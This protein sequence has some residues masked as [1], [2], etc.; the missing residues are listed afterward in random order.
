MKIGV[1]GAAHAGVAAAQAAAKE[2]A[3]VVLFSA[4]K[5]LPYFRPRLPGVAFGAVDEASI[6]MHPFEWHKKNGIDLKLGADVAAFD[7]DCGITLASGQKDKFDALVIATGAGPIMPGF[8][9]ACSPEKTVPLWSFDNAMRIKNSVSAGMTL[10]IIGGG[11]I[12]VEVALWAV[13]A[14]IK[15]LIVEKL[16]RLMPRNFGKKASSTIEKQLKTRGVEVLTG[17]TIESMDCASSPGKLL[18]ETDNGKIAA[19]LAV[20]S[21]GAACNTAA[22][23]EAGLEISSGIVVDEKLCAS[24]SSIFAAGDIACFGG[25]KQCSAKEALA[26]GKIAGFNAVAS[27]KGEALKIYEFQPA[28][29]QM[30]HKDFELYSIGGVPSDECREEILEFEEGRLY[31]ACVYNKNGVLAGAQ[32]VGSGKDFKKYEKEFLEAFNSGEK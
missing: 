32:M 3:E 27:L 21:I 23:A 31:R 18:I 29:M 5:V 7:L 19:D 9:K 15:T 25:R 14:G 4:E 10:A 8:A 11:V 22:A 30:K 20:L 12:G 17:T 24:S 1:I 2:G 26:Q 13:E 6:F 16:P 28:T